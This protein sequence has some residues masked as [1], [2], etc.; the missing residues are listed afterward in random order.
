MAKLVYEIVGVNSLGQATKQANADLYSLEQSAARTNA[1]IGK[2]ITSIAQLKR[3]IV[4]L[5]RQKVNII[6]ESK[7]ARQNKLIQELEAELKRAENIGKVGFDNVGVAIKKTGD[8]AERTRE[9]FRKIYEPGAF[10][11]VTTEIQGASSEVKGLGGVFGGLS[12]SIL[13]SLAPLALLTAGLAAAKAVFTNNVNLSDEFVDVQRTAKLSAEEVDALGDALKRIDTRTPLAGLLDIAFIGG[14]LGVAKNDMVGF[15]TTVDQL[16]VVLKK[17]FPGGAEAVANSLGKII[18]VYKIT[19]R[20]GITLDQ[21]LKNTGSAFLELAHSGQVNV[22]YLQDFA[23]RTAGIAQI[24]KISLPTMLAYGAVLSQAGISAQVA[25]TSLTRLISNLSTKR[26]AFFAIAQ[27]GDSTLTI[28]KFTNL[29]NTDTKAALESFFKGLKAG[30]PTQTEFSDRLKTLSLTTGA[31]KNAVIALAEN[32]D[33]LFQKTALANKANAEGTS[34]SHNF[35]LAN[36]SLAASIDKIGNSISNAFTSSSFARSIASFLNS[37]TSTKSEAAE[38]AEVL[39]RNK[40]ANEQLEASLKPLVNRYDELKGKSKLTTA[41]Q[42]ELRDITAKIGVLLPNVTTKF[43]EYGNSLDINRKKIN[44]LT[45]AQRELLLAQNRGV[46]KKANDLFNVQEQPK[47]IIQNAL[48]GAFGEDDKGRLRDQLIQVLGRQYELAKTIRDVGGKL[49]KSQQG[50]IDYFEKLD[51]ARKPTKTTPTI[52]GDGTET[53]LPDDGVRTID[54]IKADIKRVTDLKKPLDV[55]SKQYKEYLLQLKGF[56]AELK[57]AMGSDLG[58]GR[59]QQT[60]VKEVNLRQQLDDIINKAKTSATE[61]GLTGYALEIKQ[62]EN[63][64]L[65]LNRE[66]NKFITNVQAQERLYKKTGGKQGI[67]NSAGNALISEAQSTKAGLVSPFNKE[68]GDASIKEAERVANEIQRINN[69]FGVK[70]Q[71]SKGRELAVIQAR[72]DAEVVKAKGNAEILTALDAGRLTAIEAINAKYEAIQAD[73]QSK[74][75]G[76]QETTIATLTGREEEQTTKIQKEWETRRR[77]LNGYYADLLKIASASNFNVT[78]AGVNLNGVVAGAISGQQAKDNGNIDSAGIRAVNNYLN[79]DFNNALKG[80]TRGFVSDLTNGLFNASSQANYSFQS[81]FS[82]ITES[83]NKTIQN[84][85]FNVIQSQLEKKLQAGIDGG[86]GGLST[87]LQGIIGGLAV[88]GGLVSGL[89]PKTSVAGQGLGGALSGAASGAALGSIIPGLGTV[90]GGV[91]GG[92]IGLIGGILG[93]NKAQKELQAQQLA[94]QKQQTDLLRQ[95]IAYTASVIGRMTN[96]GVVA[97]VEVGAFGDLTTRISG[98]DIE[99]VLNRRT[100]TR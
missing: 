56:K 9:K 5:N 25:G 4:E 65:S 64:Y 46:V 14:R 91:V 12:G 3:D 30:N 15:V 35:E 87:K 53:I 81:V 40:H 39:Q 76:I 19:Q 28:E 49:T 69:E 75:L 96:Q 93:A 44:D 66:I 68:I 83:F 41:E 36:N 52:T 86:L 11:G 10:K 62:I 70:S 2:D 78:G 6:D 84:G 29:I 50:V 20:E 57:A 89:T 72:Y 60:I 77:A 99:I 80:V 23:L 16:A 22:Q 37:I 48:A 71:E 98:Q 21:A 88:A 54:D 24:A 79:K 100:R 94:E 51:K 95:S 31:A 55:A 47:A 74:I 32:Q 7:L 97:G 92:A 13:G 61:S 63:R 34:V 18:S 38:L 90:A 8:E 58:S 43:D 73:L 45:K 17:E 26:Q 82:N 59:V 85:V 27:L 33:V 1:A 67:S 42:T